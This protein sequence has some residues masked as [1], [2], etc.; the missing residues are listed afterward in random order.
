MPRSAVLTTFLFLNLIVSVAGQP[1]NDLY[2]FELRGEA[3]EARSA[4]LDG[5]GRDDVAV[6][7]TSSQGE[8]EK[9][10]FLITSAPGGLQRGQ[11]RRVSLSPDELFVAI[12]RFQPGKARQLLVLGTKGSQ[13]LFTDHVAA[14]MP[15]MVLPVGPSDKVRF[16]DAVADLDGDGLD[17]LVLPD[18]RLY[19]LWRANGSKG[20]ERGSEVLDA[21]RSTAVKDFERTG[22]SL[23]EVMG[24]LPRLML[25]DLDGDGRIDAAAAVEGKLI[26][27]PGL[28][29]AEPFGATRVVRDLPGSEGL[30]GPGRYLNR[31]WRLADLDA[32]GRAELIM[33]ENRGRLGLSSSGQGTVEISRIFGPD[34]PVIIRHLSQRGYVLGLE[35]ADVNGDGRLD[36]VTSVADFDLVGQAL[37]GQQHGEV[38]YRVFLGTATD[39]YPDRPQFTFKLKIPLSSLE[40][41]PRIPY[42]TFAG[43]FDGDGIKDVLHVDY[44]RGLIVRRVV[45]T[46]EGG[47][48]VEDKPFINLR[49]RPTAVLKLVDLN[50]DGRT[51]IIVSHRLPGTENDRIDVLLSRGPANE[52]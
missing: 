50:G 49:F 21:C 7:C 5:D 23:F 36:M 38:D 42:A 12:G 52:P 34:S 37:L 35:F 1:P 40:T 47:F 18:G 15:V 51:D 26:L 4:D 13:F 2:E 20:F 17:E 22:G 3:V 31:S 11:A 46:D 39:T 10:C 8:P 6:L 29:G 45:R 24:Q 19:R 30:T 41:N 48:R 28:S 32:D 9:Y 44:D 33:F 25:R 14:A 27:R 43:D 16:W